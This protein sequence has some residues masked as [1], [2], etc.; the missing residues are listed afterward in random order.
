[1]YKKQLATLFLDIFL[2]KKYYTLST[3][4]VVFLQ[5]FTAHNILPPYIHAVHLH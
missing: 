1:M 4:G 3:L 2:T 5:I